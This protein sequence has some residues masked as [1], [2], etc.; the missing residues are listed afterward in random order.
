ML[1]GLYA[2]NGTLFIVTDRPQDFPTIRMMISNGYPDIDDR[3]S[4]EQEQTERDMRV[5]SPTE[6]RAVFGSRAIFLEGVTVSPVLRACY[7]EIPAHCLY[8][9]F[10]R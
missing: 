2:L 4:R 6:A 8:P 9:V 7:S 10:K 3:K 1:D 5:I